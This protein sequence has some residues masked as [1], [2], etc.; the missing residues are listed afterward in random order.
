MEIKKYKN[1]SLR[2]IKEL[3][4]QGGKV[5]NYAASLEKEANDPG[6]SALAAGLKIDKG[7]DDE[8]FDGESMFGGASESN[9][10]GEGDIPEK[11][12][13]KLDKYEDQIV[14]LNFDLKDKNSKLLELLSELEDIKI[15]VFARDKSIEL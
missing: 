4:K 5:P 12:Q 10:D 13:A 9:L 7:S 15:Q 3:K 2:I 6:K 14:K 1:L 8:N 11:I